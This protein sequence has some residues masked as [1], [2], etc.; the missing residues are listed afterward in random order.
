M[1]RGAVVLVRHRNHHSTAVFA[2]GQPNT[3]IDLQQPDFQASESIPSSRAA[4]VISTILKLSLF[5]TI[6]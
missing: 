6:L 5:K 2:I 1:S 3:G 4:T